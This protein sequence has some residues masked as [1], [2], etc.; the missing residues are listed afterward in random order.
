MMFGLGIHYL[1]GWAMAAADGARKEHAEWPPH[2]DRVFMAMSAAWFETGQ[3]E[4]EKEAL[5]WLERLPAPGLAATDA[6]TRC[7][8]ESGIPV[9]SYVPV[10]DTALGKKLPDTHDSGKLKEAGLGLVPEHRPRQPRKFPV[11]IPHVPSVHLVWKEDLPQEHRGPLASLCSKVVSV[12]HSSSLVQM[13]LTDQPPSPSLAPVNSMALHRLRVFG[14]GRL[15]Y[16]KTRCN[17]DEVIR[18]R[19]VT[20]ALVSLQ[21]RKK[22]IDRKRKA[23]LKGLKG[24]DKKQAEVPFRHELEAIDDALA[25]CRKELEAFE[26]RTPNSLWPEP[27]LWQG[28]ARTSQSLQSDNPKSLFDERLVIMNITGKRLSLTSTLKLTEA[29]RGALLSACA[30]PVPEWISG[31]RPD[32]TRSLDPHLAFLPLPF[33]ASAHADGRIMGAALAL[34]RIIDK[35]EAGSILD[36]WLRDDNGLPRRIKLFDGHWLECSMELETRET[37]PWNLR[38]SSWVGPSRMWASVTPIVL[39]RHFDGKNMWEQAAIVV[40]DACERIGLPRPER[41]LLHPVSLV[42][43]APHSRDFPPVKRKF[44]NGRMHHCHAVI[45]FSEPVSGPVLV[46]AGR[47][48]GYG[49]CR[50]MDQ[51]RTTDD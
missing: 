44:D 14:P 11:A 21:E 24:P 13:W 19:E 34:P 1:N 23:A 7:A 38:S 4:Q 22:E 8:L 6:E 48:R 27:G 2:P 40:Q 33:V 42:E 3:D 35:S 18:H 37:P 41:V 28:Y 16:L 30:E 9:T 45:L 46:G 39:D 26:G 29:I 20:A 51:G 31:H 15:E 17:K 36:S 49:L 32:G 10:N 25:A 12:G 50:P 43:G 47:F 5:E